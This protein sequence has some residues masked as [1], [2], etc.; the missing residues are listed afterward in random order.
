MENRS[1]R[2]FLGRCEN[3]IASDLWKVNRLILNDTITEYNFV[4]SNG[5]LIE[6]TF[7]CRV[8]VFQS[9]Q[10]MWAEAFVS[11]GFV[12]WFTPYME[13]KLSSLEFFYM[14]KE[15]KLKGEVASKFHGKEK[16]G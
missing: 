15:E 1:Y 6:N 8:S 13:K 9:F 5:P 14:E 10:R 11:L 2:L 3:V 16:L 7:V 4:G 12:D